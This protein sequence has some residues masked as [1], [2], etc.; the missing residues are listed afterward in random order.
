MKLTLEINKK[1][2]PTNQEVGIV[3]P[4]ILM[5]PAI[6]D[7]YWKYRVKLCKDQAILGFPKFGTVGIGFA[8]EEDWNTNL[9]FRCEVEKIYNH[10]KH[11]KKYK[12]IKK[13]DCIKA[14]GLIKGYIESQEVK[15]G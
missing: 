10:I 11:N 6:G 4:H 8:K 15:N 14:I 12:Q 9:P 1:F 3:S 7:D 2:A 13:S 5:T